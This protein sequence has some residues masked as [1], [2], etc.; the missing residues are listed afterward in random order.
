MEKLG[1]IDKERYFEISEKGGY[2]KRCPILHRCER[3]AC[4]LFLSHVRD[5]FVLNKDAGSFEQFKENL[6]DTGDI[7][8]VN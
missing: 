7:Q 6:L 2:P 5:C 3:R 8:H 1:A 4:T